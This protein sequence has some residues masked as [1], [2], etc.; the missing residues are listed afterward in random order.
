MT[1]KFNDYFRVCILETPQEIAPLEELQAL[2]WPGDKAEVVPQHVLLAV[3]HNG[4]LVIGAYQVSELDES[5]KIEFTPF[6]LASA[7]NL[8]T[9]AKLV[10]FVFGFPGIYHTADGPRLKHHSHMMGVH[11]EIRDVGVGFALKR[12]QWQM[13][14]HQNID[15]ITWTYDPLQ[16]RNGRLNIAR[17]GA[18]CNTYLCDAYGTMRDG[19]NAGLPSD[20][21]QVDWWTYSQRVAKRMS[22]QPRLQLDLAH[23]L[24]AGTPILN[25]T[26]LDGSNLPHP[27]GS[28]NEGIMEDAPET[29]L[30]L[31][32]IPADFP[33]IRS[34]DL[35]LALTWRLHIRA[36]MEGLFELGYVITD[37]IYLSGAHAR[38]FYVLSHGDSTL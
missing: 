29:P 2:V 33:A 13:V 27:V 20:R 9:G 11:P 16:S 25:P 31:L 18:V 21:L 6:P 37:F 26:F 34:A 8:P 19:L 4:G 36:W 7:G 10:G 30:V 24:A 1:G 35:G 12:A 17:L 22:L 32:E 23:Y 15:R 38:S 3:A 14:R 28:G 5:K